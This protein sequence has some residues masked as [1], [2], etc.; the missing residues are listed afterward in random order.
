[1]QRFNT[2]FTLYNNLGDLNR[3]SYTFYYYDGK[4]VLDEYA[5]ETR[6][7]KRHGWKNHGRWWKRMNDRDSRIKRAE[8]T[9]P[10]G[11]RM[12]A[13]K[14]IQDQIYFEG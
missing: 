14:F 7:T 8:I 5:E 13:I 3:E 11:I 4:I 1:M 6:E 2:R 9:V 10:T 12:Q